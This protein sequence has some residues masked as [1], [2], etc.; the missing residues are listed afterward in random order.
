MGDGRDVVVGDHNALHN[1]GDA[2]DDY[3]D[4]GDGDDLFLIGDS[5]WGEESGANTFE[6]EAGDDT[7]LGGAGNDG[8]I[9]GDH[10]PFTGTIPGPGGDDVLK[11]GTGD[12]ALFGDH[13]AD[14][15]GV[16]SGNGD[17]ACDG[18]R[19]RIRPR[20]V[21]T[22]PASRRRGV[23]SRFLHATWRGKRGPAR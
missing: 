21:K 14:G 19:G 10:N 20:R 23:A 8:A 1:V 6:G 12:D 4:G 16:T 9:I 17:D 13:F 3:I 5:S 11:G 2:G 15:D 7:I 22:S 18:G